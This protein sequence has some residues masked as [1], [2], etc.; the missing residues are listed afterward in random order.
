[1]DICHIILG[2]PWQFDVGATHDGRS[3]TYSFDWKGR[4]IILMPQTLSAS[5]RN[6]QATMFVVSGASLIHLWQ[7]NSVMFALIAEA[8]ETGRVSPNVPSTVQPI[9]QQFTEFWPSELPSALPPLREIQHQIDFQ[10]GAVQPCAVPALLVPKKDKTVAT[11]YMIARAI[12][13]Q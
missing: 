11:M 3:N 5:D 7:E 4:K 6:E 9:L 13:G 1:M 10:P 12:A 2:R 8:A